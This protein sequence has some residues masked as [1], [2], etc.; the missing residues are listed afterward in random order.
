M[1]HNT[2][3]SAYYSLKPG[4]PRW[5][6]VELRRI[7]VSIRRPFVGGIWPI[8][9]SAGEPPNA[10]VGWPEGKRFAFIITHDVEGPSGV[11]RCRELADVDQSLGFRS[12]FNFVPE[13]S[14]S[15][16]EV[17]YELIEKG[18]EVGVHGLRHDGNLYSSRKKFNATAK[19]IRAYLND[20][21]SVGF[22]TPSMYHNLDWIGELGV[23]Y[24][25][26]TFDTDP[27]EPQEDGVKTI[28]PLWIQE[29]SRAKGYVELPYTLPQDF[30]LFILMKE[31]TIDIWKR[32]LDW[33]VEKGG[34][35]L[36]ITHPDY[37]DFGKGTGG[38]E[39]YPVRFYRELLNHVERSYGKVYWNP[40]PRDL[41]GFWKNAMA[42]NT[43]TQEQ[44]S[45]NVEKRYY[46]A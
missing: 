27:Y 30:T 44:R 46:L 38:R 5:L 13:S 16:E 34:M 4:I 36:S 6:Q 23:E 24:D 12:S 35:A 10:W 32:K 41:A 29:H 20:W 19:T 37:M 2:L 7:M 18:F 3:L 15:L 22:R 21:Q 26:S 28:F 8:D 45:S 42:G 11:R 39:E 14:G 43:V 1:L 33:I 40:L 31:K 9:E 17:R 25:S